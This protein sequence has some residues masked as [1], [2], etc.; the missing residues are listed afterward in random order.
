MPRVSS[1]VGYPGNA[2]GKLNLLRLQ[3][4]RSRSIDVGVAD[5]ESF[6]VVPS[7]TTTQTKNQNIPLAI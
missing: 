2:C 5:W 4:L 6:A 1:V 7:I 3:R